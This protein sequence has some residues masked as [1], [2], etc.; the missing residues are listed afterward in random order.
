MTEKLNLTRP[1]MLPELV[2]K[3]GKGGSKH[4]IGLADWSTRIHSTVDKKGNKY[5]EYVEV[6]F[7][8][9]CESVKYEIIE[10]ER[11][12]VLRYYWN[13]FDKKDLADWTHL[14]MPCEEYFGL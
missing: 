3:N 14:D 7:L 2:R 4:S 12:V 9:G 1:I 5:N 10:T 11:E 13:D 8:K 6:I